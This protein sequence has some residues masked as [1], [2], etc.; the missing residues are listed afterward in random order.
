MSKIFPL[1][2]NKYVGKQSQNVQTDINNSLSTSSSNLV[3]MGQLIYIASEGYPR[4]TETTPK[5]NLTLPSV[6]EW[7]LK[8]D[9]VALYQTF[10]EI[11]LGSLPSCSNF[12][13]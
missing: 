5:K 3:T 8:F 7:G 12:I 1:K 4:P 11:R 10:S 2:M 6:F 9:L 13:H